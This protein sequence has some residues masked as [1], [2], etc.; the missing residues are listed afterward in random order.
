MRLGVVHEPRLAVVHELG[1]AV[2]E[3]LGLAVVHELGCAL[4][5]GR[6]LGL[7]HQLRLSLVGSWFRGSLRRGRLGIRPGHVHENGLPASVRRIRRHGDADPLAARRAEGCVDWELGTTV[8]T[9][10]RTTS[11]TNP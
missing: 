3:K 5:R 10:H 1:L 8:R 2:I 11:G 7:V 6:S 4:V 9:L